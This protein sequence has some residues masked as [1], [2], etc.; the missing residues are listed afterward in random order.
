[1][2]GVSLPRFYH[3]QLAT[4][5]RTLDPAE[6]RHA[7]GAR[8]LRAGERVVLFDG[9]GREADAE[10]LHAAGATMTVRVHAVRT[11][12]RAACCRLTLAFSPPRPTRQDTLIEK[13]TELGVA[14]L[15]PIRV[16]RSVADAPCS[17]LER[18]HRVAVAAAKQSQQA[19]LPEIAEA[20]SLASLLEHA[21]EH[22]LVLVADPA[23]VSPSLASILDRRPP[24]GSV[25][26]LVGPEGGFTEPEIAAAR[27]AGAVACRLV[28]SI[29]RVE[30]AAIAVAAIVLAR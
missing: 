29:L 18:W 11:V 26:A 17:R 27:D 28:P 21:A 9:Q 22:D 20:V 5:E 12:P 3:P 13:C 30:T 8:R 2:H 6:A 1:M 23:P 7:A 4:D 19:W 10:L 14:V 16:E 24:S 15:Q 25:L